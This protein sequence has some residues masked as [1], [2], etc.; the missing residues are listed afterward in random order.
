MKLSEG[1]APMKISEKTWVGVVAGLVVCA[2]L[3]D[4]T[5]TEKTKYLIRP[6]YHRGQ[7]LVYSLSVAGSTAW[8]PE[9]NDLSG[10]EMATDFLF[11][12]AHKRSRESGAC[13]FDLRGRKLR[14]RVKND[15]GTISIQAD[16]RECELDVQG[17]GFDI[18][19]GNPLKHETTLTLGPRGGVRYGT[20][21]LRL[22]PYFVVHVNPHFWRALTLA[23]REEV[24]VGD[25][26]QESF[27]F[28]IPD[29]TGR[30]LEVDLRV[31]V[32]GWETYRGH[33]CLAG[34]AAARLRLKK[35]RVTLKNGDLLLVDR[36]EYEAEG[37]VLWDPAKGLLRYVTARNR[38]TVRSSKPGTRRFSGSARCTLKLLAAE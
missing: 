10:G 19:K 37:K 27:E 34:R 5:G 6:K 35:T 26:W 2:A 31:R 28:R 1:E 14:S 18:D 9:H 4:A 25:E 29:S 20:G 32:I 17:R 16:P 21:L 33:R 3:A 8:Q 7:K 24:A 30:P 12:L 36:G 23:P 11:T 15:K 13:T 22:A 38:L